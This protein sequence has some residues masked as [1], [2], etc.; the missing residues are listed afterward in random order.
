MNRRRT[1]SEPRRNPIINPS[2]RHLLIGGLGLT[3]LIATSAC[4]AL[5]DGSP[6]AGAGGAPQG[7][8]A[9]LAPL[10]LAGAD[11][12]RIIDTLDA[13]PVA[14]RPAGVMASIRP[15]QLILKGADGAEATIAMPG[16]FYVSFAPYLAQTHDCFFH[17][18]TTCRGELANA[19]IHVTVTADDGRVLLDE[20]RTTF[21]NGFSGLWLPR[22]IRAKL[23]VTHDGRS[24]ETSI[25]TGKDDP[26]CLTT[27]KLV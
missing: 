2:R 9:I 16:E 24:F 17:S 15:E 18:L 27:V 3:T 4:T 19:P 14:E 7:A 23:A 20:D 26:T 6:A 1:S 25:G 21:D 22:D 11:A 8:D 10:G 12:K 5:P 13:Q